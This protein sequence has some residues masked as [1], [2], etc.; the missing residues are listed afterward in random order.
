MCAASPEPRRCL[1]ISSLV[2]L[3]ACSLG[4]LHGVC[5]VSSQGL[6]CSLVLEMV[7]NIQALRSET[8]LLLAGKVALVSRL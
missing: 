7:N 6:S 8:E 2:P 4:L 3:D 1:H 5:S